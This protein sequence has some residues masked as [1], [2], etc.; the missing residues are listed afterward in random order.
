MLPQLVWNCSSCCCSCG[1]VIDAIPNGMLAL[2]ASMRVA[3]DSGALKPVL[4][5][6]LPG[7]TTGP[8]ATAGNCET[9]MGSIC[10]G[11]GCVCM[12]TKACGAATMIALATA[13]SSVTIAAAGSAGINECVGWMIIWDASLV[14][15][16]NADTATS[17]YAGM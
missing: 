12:V 7:N 3:C 4:A 8:F 5:T 17:E 2:L 6:T 14:P 9:N 11:C 15:V 10:C 16:P 13:T 1:L